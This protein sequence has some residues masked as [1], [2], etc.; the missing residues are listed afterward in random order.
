METR[1]ELL[2]T[3]NPKVISRCL[4]APDAT[5]LHHCLQQYFTILSLIQALDTKR[6]V[7]SLGKGN[8]LGVY[9]P[10]PFYP[11]SVVHFQLQGGMVSHMQ[12]LAT[13]S[14]TVNNN[15]YLDPYH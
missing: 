12:V 13:P 9:M 11:A 7:A 8:F 14:S 10:F 2:T 1:V 15:K 4:S 6:P 5:S 3:S